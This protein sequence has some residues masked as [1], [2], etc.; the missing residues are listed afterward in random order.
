MT[1]AVPQDAVRAV[2]LELDQCR[3]RIHRILANAKE[4]T[5]GDVLGIVDQVEQVLEESRGH[6]DDIE[7]AVSSAGPPDGIRQALGEQSELLDGFIRE[8]QHRTERLQD[9][10]TEAEA[11]LNRIAR[12][13]GRIDDVAKAVRILAVNARIESTRIQGGE[14]FSSIAAQMTQLSRQVETANRAV[15]STVDRLVD[16]LPEIGSTAGALR[17]R[18]QKYGHQAQ[19][20]SNQLSQDGARLQDA[21][22]SCRDAGSSRLSRIVA[23]AEEAFHGLAFQDPLFQR[24]MRIDT[25]LFEVRVRVLRDLGQSPDTASRTRKPMHEE[26]SR[27]LPKPA[28]GELELADNEIN[29]L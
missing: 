19:G 7:R 1:T 24:L 12:I 26:A 8:L 3:E 25:E 2:Q 11:A 18:S 29:F 17:A 22:R 27:N 9:L 10:A 20:L 23:A 21:L 16:M 15:A 4:R 14:G 13:G 6:I 28:S 5:D